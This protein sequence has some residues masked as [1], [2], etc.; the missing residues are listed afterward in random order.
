[1]SKCDR[2]SDLTGSNLVAESDYIYDEFGRLTN[3]IHLGATAILA[4]YNWVYDEANRIISF[5]S[6][7][8]V[9]NYSYDDKDQF[10]LLISALVIRGVSLMKRR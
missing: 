3:L 2:Y 5:T 10:L 4:S 6:P 7:D 9:A 1:M 8:G